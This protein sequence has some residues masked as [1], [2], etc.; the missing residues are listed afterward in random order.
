[1]MTLYVAAF[2][3]VMKLLLHLSLYFRSKLM[4]G[5]T[6]FEAAIISVVMVTIHT[7]DCVVLAMVEIDRKQ[8]SVA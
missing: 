1:M 7:G 8:R 5:I 4:A 3:Q 6:G 2:T